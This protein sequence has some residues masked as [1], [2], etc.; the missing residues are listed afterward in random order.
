MNQK[1]SRLHRDE[2]SLLKSG[3]GVAMALWVSSALMPVLH[4]TDNRRDVYRS[5]T[6]PFGQPGECQ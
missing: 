5:T 6:V 2:K 4:P 3:D 1:N